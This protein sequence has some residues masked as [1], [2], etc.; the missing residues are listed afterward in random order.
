M[1]TLYISYFGSS[2]PLVH[3][4][5]V[6]YLATIAQSG[7]DV[8][9]MTFEDPADAGDDEAERRVRMRHDLSARGISWVPLRY[10]KRPSL[11]ATAYDTLVGIAVAAWLVR[12]RGIEVVHARN[13]VPGLMALAIKRLLGTKVLFDQRGVMAEEYVDAGIWRE[14]SIPF[15]LIK[16]V[17]RRL[18]RDADAIVMLTRRIHEALRERSQELRQSQVPVEIIPCCVDLERFRQPSS[19]AA[20]KRLGLEGKRVLVYAGS[21]GGSYM[22]DEMLRLFAA[23]RA[24]DPS[25]HF[26]LLSPGGEA[27]VHQ[28]LD[29]HGIPRD[30]CTTLGVPPAAIPEYLAASDLGVSFAKPC[31]SRLGCSPTKIGEYL[32]CGLPVITGPG[33]GDVDDIIT[34]DDVGVL[35][36]RFDDAA[37]SAAMERALALAGDPAV[38]GRCRRSA[39]KNFSL[40]RIGREGYLRVYRQ[41]GWRDSIGAA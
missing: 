36:D 13:H 1:R 28:A 26:L 14:G 10:H 20:R 5:V 29:R 6:P 24:L 35:V 39:E 34:G 23:G 27:A 9:L 21:I 17:E 8:T 37:Y 41:L 22:L 3:T 19:S 30:A 25:L 31:F 40:E 12:S 7:I 16:A 2:K 11:A 32:A 18:F 38:A 15:R 33:I 4:Q